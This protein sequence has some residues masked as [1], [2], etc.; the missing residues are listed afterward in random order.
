MQVDVHFIIFVLPACVEEM[1]EDYESQDEAA[2][3]TDIS[4]Y[5]ERINSVNDI[6]DKQTWWKDEDSGRWFIDGTLPAF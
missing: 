1:D 5:H 6:R 4:Y 2:V 3:T